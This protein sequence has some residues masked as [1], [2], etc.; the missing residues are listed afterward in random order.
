MDLARVLAR[1]RELV[2]QK[3]SF[4]FETTLSGRSYRQLIPK[5]SESGFRV[6][7]LFLWLPSSDLAVER[8]DVRVRQGGHNIPEPDVRRRFDRGLRNLFEL[9]I[10][11]VDDAYVYNAGPLPPELVWSRQAGQEVIAVE[12]AWQLVLDSRTDVS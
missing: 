3:V 4:A 7:L 2:E 10:P 5:W 8:V 1:I 9:Y 6:V 12:A 11:C